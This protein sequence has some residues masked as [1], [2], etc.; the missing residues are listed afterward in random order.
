LL[1]GD[2]RRDEDALPLGNR[3]RFGL[4]E[5]LDIKCD[6]LAIGFTSSP[7]PKYEAWLTLPSRGSRCRRGAHTDFASVR[8]PSRG[9]RHLGF[10]HATFAFV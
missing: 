4:I 1:P 5:R 2:D 7:N 9:R 3:E 8:P 6:R 10:A